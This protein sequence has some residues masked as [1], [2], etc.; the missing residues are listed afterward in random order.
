MLEEFIVYMEESPLLSS[1]EKFN[2]PER[3][4]R[5]ALFIPAGL[6]IGTGMGIAS[7][8]IFSGAFVGLGF[9]FA[10]FAISLFFRK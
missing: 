8:N 7:E 1:Q 6:F 4:T 5:G 2:K 9:G 10:I 3:V